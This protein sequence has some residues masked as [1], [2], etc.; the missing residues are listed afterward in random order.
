MAIAFDATANI[1]DTEVTEVILSH[2]CAG[3]DRLLMVGVSFLSGTT[4]TGITYGTTPVA[5]TK[6]RHDDD[7][8]VARTEL[9]YLVA[10][11]TGTHDITVTFDGS[12][13]FV[14]VGSISLTGVDQTSPLDSNNGATGASGTAS[15]DVTTVATD[16]WITDVVAQ[17]GENDIP[18]AGTGQTER[19]ATA[20]DSAGAGGSTEVATSAAAYTMDWTMAD[21]T[22]WAISGASW[23][24]AGAGP[25]P[26]IVPLAYNHYARQRMNT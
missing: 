8:S 1:G 19:W 20:N 23:K 2:V 6:V 16:A 11:V 5:L 26:S 22:E 13:E 25:G 24:P 15:V 14:T 17:P 21:T 12:T 18:A 9:W 10:P 3:T 4:I 7:A